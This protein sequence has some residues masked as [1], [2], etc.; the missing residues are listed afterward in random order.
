MNGMSKPADLAPGDTLERI[1]FRESSGL[2][3]DGDF[4]APPGTAFD[5]LSLPPDRL[6]GNAMVVRYEILKPLPE[7]VRTGQIAPG[8]EQPGLGTQY[9]FPD[10]IQE[11]VDGKYLK[12]IP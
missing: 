10:G 7:N 12:E 3:A 6:G 2:P 8:F 1:T 9:H 4:A 11:L 5:K